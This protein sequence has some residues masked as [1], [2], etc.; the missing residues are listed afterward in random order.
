MPDFPDQSEDR[1]GWRIAFAVLFFGACALGP[2]LQVGTVGTASAKHPL[3]DWEVEAVLEGHFA[4]DLEAHLERAS[5]ITAL[6]RTR[7]RET[8]WML[9]LF[10]DPL[11]EIRPGGW[12][13]LK[14]NAVP[15]DAD[16][17]RA[18][19]IAFFEA[20][21][22]RV[23][24]DGVSLVVVVAP[25][26]AR[27]YPDRA[28]DGPMDAVRERRYAVLLAELASAG[29][30]TIDAATLLRQ[31]R[32]TL[33]G[34]RLYSKVDSHWSPTGAGLVARAVAAHLRAVDVPLGPPV[35]S[36]VLI[37]PFWREWDN[38]LEGL[39]F[40][41]INAPMRW[42]LERQ[43]QF[44]QWVEGAAQDSVP[45][46]DP[47]VALCGDSFGVGIGDLLPIALS[48]EVDHRDV[49]PGEGPCA[50]LLR[51][52]DRISSGASTTRTV[53]WVFIERA[54]QY[55]NVWRE[56]DLAQVRGGGR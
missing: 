19:R 30:P 7:F 54:M 9:G 46:P 53:V 44:S 51:R 27:I 31:R 20:V 16:P 18:P 50:G 52:L 28:F 42:T 45:T 29:L 1:R 55:A 33:P 38:M 32:R 6:L 49:L 34:E 47:W 37:L 39:G 15:P 21:A 56:P 11:R 23:R 24:R 2:L 48:R 3:P 10:A 12:L 40:D 17:A 41:S 26:K 25:D 8:E 13:F 4:R 5:P 43:S 35:S 36:E 14:V 22:D